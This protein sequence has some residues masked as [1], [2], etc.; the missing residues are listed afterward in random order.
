MEVLYG[1]RRRR[2][3]EPW[4][5]EKERRLTKGR[6]AGVAMGVGIGDL[7]WPGVVGHLFPFFFF[8]ATTSDSLFPFFLVLFFL[9]ISDQ[10]LYFSFFLRS[11][12][13]L[14]DP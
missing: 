10:A 8:L 7:Q 3:E 11:L 12:P 13:L 5:R 4:R 6:M 1:A 14:S 9:F 2:K